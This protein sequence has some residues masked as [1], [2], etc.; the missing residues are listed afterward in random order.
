MD[1]TELGVKDVVDDA[2]P[3][4]AAVEKEVKLLDIALMNK[5]RRDMIG[6]VASDR[7]IEDVNAVGQ[8]LVTLQEI[9][10][11]YGLA[12]RMLMG[13]ALKLAPHRCGSEADDANAILSG[14]VQGFAQPVES[15]VIYADASANVVNP[16]LH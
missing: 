12:A 5:D 11:S 15:T 10:F 16:V 13:V 1:Q 3:S 4:V 7:A 8:G 2:L 6:R 9:A 14:F